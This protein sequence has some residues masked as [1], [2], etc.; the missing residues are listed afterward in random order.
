MVSDRKVV[1]EDM[2]LEQEY[3]KLVSRR[4][5]LQKQE[6]TLRREFTTLLRKIASITAVLETLE[7]REILERKLPSK[8]TIA[9][10]PELQYLVDSLQSLDELLL[11]QVQIPEKLMHSYELFRNTPLLYKDNPNHV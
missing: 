10:V 2:T 1:K 11:E 4:D 6:I 5:E 8:E 3:N 7:D 9:K